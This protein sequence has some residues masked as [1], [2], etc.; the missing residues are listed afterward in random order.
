MRSLVCILLVETAGRLLHSRNGSVWL[1]VTYVTDVIIEVRK[2]QCPDSGME[3]GTKT[4]YIY[5]GSK[6]FFTVN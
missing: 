5:K 4:T 2:I 3:Y 6:P 1:F